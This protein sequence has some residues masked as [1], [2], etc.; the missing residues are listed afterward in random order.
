[1]KELFRQVA[2]WM[3]PAVALHPQLGKPP[4]SSIASHLP[5]EDLVP[6][7][8]GG[9]A[10]LLANGRLG[11]AWSVELLDSEFGL[12]EAV[13]LQV[14]RELSRLEDPT[15]IVQLIWDSTP[16]WHLDRPARDES[17][18]RRLMEAHLAELERWAHGGLV[19]RG[20]FRAMHRALHL[21]FC[22]DGVGPS[23][24]W[25]PLGFEAAEARDMAALRQ[26]L[27]RLEA[28]ASDLQ[29]GLEGTGLV[30]RKCDPNALLQLLR[31]PWVPEARWRD[32]DCGPQRPYDPSRQLAA[33]VAKDD[34]RVAPGGFQVGDDS[35][36]LLTWVAQPRLI[37][38]GVL[39]ALLDVDA[40]VR[41]VVVIR[42]RVPTD[43]LPAKQAQMATGFE[44]FAM[45]AQRE[46]FRQ[47]AAQQHAGERLVGLTLAAM[48]RSEGVALEGLARD[49][50]GRATQRLLETHTGIDWTIETHAMLA[51]HL[52]LQPFAT[53][54]EGLRFLGRE[55]RVLAPSV[56]SAY[57]PLDGGFRGETASKHH[58]LPMVSRA[59]TPGWLSPFADPEAAH[60]TVLGSTG[61]GK[62]SLVAQLLTA[63]RAWDPNTLV[64]ILDAQTSYE[65]L[66]QILGEDRFVFVKPPKTHVS[67]W[68]G[69][70]DG[71]RLGVLVALLR[72]AIEL[73]DDTAALTSQ[74]LQLL[75]HA[76][77]EAYAHRDLMAQ[78]EMVPA[79]QG[80]LAAAPP[81]ARKP[82]VRLSDVLAGLAPGAAKLELPA[83]IGVE[84]AQWLAPYVGSGPYAALLDAAGEELSEPLPPKVVLF[85]LGDLEDPVLHA[86]Y[87]AM[88]VSEVLRAV[89]ANKCR[90][91]VVIE[92]LGVLLKA[93]ALAAF[94][95]DFWKIARKL[96]VACIALSNHLDDYIQLPAGRA[97][98][99]NSPHHVFL[100]MAD[101][102]IQRAVAEGLMTPPAAR[103]AATLQKDPGVVTEA[104]WLSN[105]ARGSVLVPQG[106]LLRWATTTHPREA[107]VVRQVSARLGLEDGLNWLATHHP[108]GVWDQQGAPR[109]LHA[110]ELPP[111]TEGSCGG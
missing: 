9:H 65:V 42:P 75:A 48:V 29:Q 110:S 46:D 1:M 2:R 14:A 93:P 102:Q 22:I 76:I 50:V 8:R 26:A 20:A 61:A 96:D 25:G 56:L 97:V 84:L 44:S 100:P 69:T 81:Q 98:W 94:V 89:A 18:A 90:A 77:Q 103:I 27:D 57:L 38:R 5:F 21:T 72:L 15:A 4:P 54:D 19:N 74:H 37:E 31:R 3:G 49:G 11:V 92:E 39:R 58:V 17:P 105:G 32:H 63:V 107:E 53:T 106:P 52:L 12:D 99:E 41:A 35:T 34:I 16:A 66:G 82:R 73:V 70:L 43:D 71:A 62:S 86:L 24:F 10:V 68:A 78:T 91:M 45:D 79:D 101:T 13:L 104:L 40:P 7:P 64:A 108:N 87:A 95:Q 60:L 83:L 88:S 85:D 80:L 51:F 6:L 109:T 33:Q 67:V 59:G 23:S 47:L 36:Q 28:Q 111:S 30:V 55:R